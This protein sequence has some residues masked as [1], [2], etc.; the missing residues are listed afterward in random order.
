MDRPPGGQTKSF[1]YFVRGGQTSSSLQDLNL[2]CGA[3][4]PQRPA[5]RLTIGISRRVNVGVRCE[6]VG[7]V[8]C[9]KIE[10]REQLKDV[11]LVKCEIDGK[12]TGHNG[13]NIISPS[14]HYSRYTRDT[15]G[16]QIGRQRS[17]CSHTDEHPTS[18]PLVGFFYRDRL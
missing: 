18:E 16:L 12:V 7:K 10:F 4:L 2:T 11:S 15:R 9:P 5:R 17:P 6:H 8:T 14:I 3:P 13:Q 1:P